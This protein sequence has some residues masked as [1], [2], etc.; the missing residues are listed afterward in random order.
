MLSSSIRETSPLSKTDEKSAYPCEG[1]KHD[2]ATGLRCEAF[3][4]GK[5]IIVLSGVD[6]HRDSLPGDHGL[7]FEPRKPV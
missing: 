3:P 1:C 4:E 7:R 6:R 2:R 5:P